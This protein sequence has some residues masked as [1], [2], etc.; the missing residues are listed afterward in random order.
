MEG[1]GGSRSKQKIGG[2][3][4]AKTYAIHA[5]SS[6]ET[7]HTFLEDL[8]SGGRTGGKPK[9]WERFVFASLTSS[10]TTGYITE[11]LQKWNFSSSL[12]NFFIHRPAICQFI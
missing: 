9:F 2:G 4:G 5:L 10:T 12:I 6:L 1:V 8:N 11:I 3:G 7:K